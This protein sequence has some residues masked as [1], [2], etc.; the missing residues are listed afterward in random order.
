MRPLCMQGQ[1]QGQG[2]GRKD[3][4]QPVWRQFAYCL[5]TWSVPFVLRCLRRLTAC[6]DIR[7]HFP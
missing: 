2:Q 5:L 1:G 6:T 3:A 4:A 7:R